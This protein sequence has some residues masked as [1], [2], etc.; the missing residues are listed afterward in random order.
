[1]K[2]AALILN[3]VLLVAVGVLFYL[4]FSSRKSAASPVVKSASNSDSF[5]K[6]F[7]IAYFELDSINNAFTKMK[8]VKSELSKEEEKM[9]SE[10][11][12]LQKLYNDKL[13]HYQ[14]MGEMSQV[15]SEAASREMMQLQETIRGQKQTMDQKFQD[16]WM[17]KMQEVKVEV[18]QFLKEY[19]KTK[20]YSYIL[21]HEPNFI[22]YR[23]T[24]YDI[25]ADLVK[26]LNEK[27]SKKGK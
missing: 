4:H 10:M 15:Q 24:V 6:E 23:D 16:L 18:E 22:Y 3:A 20:G 9:G 5:N 11:N 8:D 2:N 21:A 26:G 19:N 17:R 7:R 27:Y 25:T 12:R 13:A 1:M 14:N